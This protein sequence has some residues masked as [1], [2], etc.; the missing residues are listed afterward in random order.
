M[1]L[2]INFV[3]AERQYESLWDNDIKQEICASFKEW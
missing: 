1:K 3:D 2:V